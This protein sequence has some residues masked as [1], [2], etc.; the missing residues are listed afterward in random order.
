M[1]GL[2]FQDLSLPVMRSN[3]V[4]GEGYASAHPDVVASVMALPNSGRP[5]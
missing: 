3:R 1:P 4:F 5:D 2:Q